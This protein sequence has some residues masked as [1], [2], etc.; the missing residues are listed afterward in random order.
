[1]FHEPTN[2]PSPE[3]KSAHFETAADAR[4]YIAWKGTV[5]AP[6]RTIVERAHQGRAPE[7]SKTQLPLTDQFL[8]GLADS[9][10]ARALHLSPDAPKIIHNV[11]APLAHLS[12][13]DTT[14]INVFEKLA[15]SATSWELKHSL[16]ET[17]LKSALDWLIAKDVAASAEHAVS[18][19]TA[20]EES[21]DNEE[22]SES[23]SQSAPDSQETP[24]S[25]EEVM[26]SMET[27]DGPEGGTEKEP[28]KPHFTVTP[29]RGGFFGQRIFD[30]FDNE[31]LKWVPMQKVF[32]PARTEDHDPTTQSVLAG[33]I[34]GNTRLA[35][36][37]QKNGT[38]I[39]ESFSTTAPRS[40]VKLEQDQHGVWYVTILAPGIHTYSI[41]AAS[42]LRQKEQLLPDIQHVGGTLP[43]ELTKKISEIRASRAPTLVQA[44]ALVK[45]IRD[46]LT[47]SN[48]K[49]AWDTYAAQPEHF[50]TQLWNRKEAD[51]HVS[52]TL[53]VR[54]LLELGV[55]AQFLG[56]YFVKEKNEQGDA[57]L[58]SGN[59]HAKLRIWDAQSAQYIELDATPA[60]DPNVDQ[61]EQEQELSDA[62]AGEDTNDAQDDELMSSEEAEQQLEQLEPSEKKK[63]KEKKSPADRE[64]AVFA[65]LAQCSPDQAKE[66]LRALDRVRAIKNEQGESISEELIHEWQKII[67]ERV[68]ETH[69]YRGPVRMSEGDHLDDPVMAYIDVRGGD[70][71]PSG[72]E[73]EMRVEQREKIFGGI[74]LYFSFDLSGSM[75]WPDGVTGR[76]RAAVQCDT[77][78]LFIDSI[79]QCAFLARQAAPQLPE[80]LPIKI[81]AT[82][83]S[84]T[85]SVALPLTDKWGPQEQWAVYT[86]LTRCADG[87]TPTHTT[88]KLIEAAYLEERLKLVNKNI[89][90]Q[91]MPLS[92]MTVISDGTPDDPEKTEQVRKRL[93]KNGMVTRTFCIGGDS[94]SPDA[95]SRLESFSQLP[96]EL[97]RDILEQFKRLHPHRV[98]E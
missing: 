48:S 2:A 7:F 72:F 25:S 78:L 74:S 76:T 64:A 24:P 44:R 53:A 95:A 87:G 26:S 56:G 37:F 89:A 38:F 50:F 41:S 60:G 71:D 88:L 16:Y 45:F 17:Q 35:L 42:M 33:K 98:T 23:Q 27:E 30:E 40:A 46:S 77:A 12:I 69:D 31:K 85:G 4:A 34:Q 62:P 97:G 79:M 82:V 9:I 13:D 36:P 14:K 90:P 86:A 6:V 19:E 73:K 93:A 3:K 92:Y 52:N 29:F 1:M 59:G 84:S 47:Y 81:M 83:A 91:D 58:Y 8:Q 10:A 49:T 67:E 39:L 20:E 22:T 21:G 61:S 70:H 15:S 66:F 51:C 65:G 96:N 75:G 80:E 57:V 68:T 32:A 18:Q 94:D 63:P 54:A 28:M 5:P 43:G 55:R 11:L